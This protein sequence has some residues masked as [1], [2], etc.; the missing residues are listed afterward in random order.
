MS[1][2]RELL[3][4]LLDYIKEQ[5]KEVDPKGYTLTST[6]GFIR[7]RNDI[8]G[9]LG[10]EFDLRIAGDHVWLRVPRL[11]AERPPDP[12]Q[13]HNALFRIN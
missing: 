3:V 13:S 10:V 9:L 5:A 2:P 7:R 6:K 11:V 1:D 4:S 12:P 8:A